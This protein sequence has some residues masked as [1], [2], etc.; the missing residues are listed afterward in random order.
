[1][2][3]KVRKPRGSQWSL[4]GS[5]VECCLLG[6]HWQML[7]QKMSSENEYLPHSIIKNKPERSE[8]AWLC[9][10]SSKKNQP[11][12]WPRRARCG[13]CVPASRR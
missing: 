10:M 4:D 7:V 3:M 9:L 8:I 11:D 13:K 5:S 2:C 12:C 1:M 6:L